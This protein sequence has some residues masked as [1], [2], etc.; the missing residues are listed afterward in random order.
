M[1]INIILFI[2]II[3][4]SFV[5]V[6]IGA[7]AFE[8]TGMDWDQA[9]FQALSC[10]TGTGFTTREAEMV[11]VVPQ[12]RRIA[13]FLMI[14]GNAGFVT[15]IA[16]LVNTMRPSTFVDAIEIPFIHRLIPVSLMPWIK[17]VFLLLM[18]FGIYKLLTSTRLSRRITIMLRERIIR[19]KIIKPTTLQEMLVGTEGYGVSTIEVDTRSHMLNQSIKES[20]LKEHDIIILAVER[21]GAIIPNPAAETRILLRDKLI[22]FGKLDNIRKEVYP[23]ILENVSGEGPST[24]S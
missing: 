16:A 3:L 2:I 10:F 9:K 19:R 12:R 5:V 17:L 13:T 22:C 20:D 1:I 8:I 14:L 4:I 24:S 21:K 11:T 18:I 23:D 7:I 6:R 15:L